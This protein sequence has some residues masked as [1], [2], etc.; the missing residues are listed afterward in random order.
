MK[1]LNLGCGAVFSKEKNW[2]NI[3]FYSSSQFVSSHNLLEGIP[4]PD[5]NFDVIYHS[6]VLE[7]FTKHEALIFLKECYR[8]L[9]PNGIIRI[10]VPDLECIIHEYLTNLNLLKENPNDEIISQ[11]YNWIMLEL[12]DQL[13]RN[14]NGG[15]MGKFLIKKDLK[16]LD[17]IIDRVGNEAVKY[18]EWKLL[19]GSEEIKSNKTNKRSL[20]TF[21]K[22]RKKKNTPSVHDEIGKFRLSGEVHQ[23][24]YDQFSLKHLIHEVGFNEITKNDAF[25]SQIPNWNS[26]NLD[27]IDG[28]IRK[29]DSLFMEAYKN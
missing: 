5:S 22:N 4:F 26:Y 7:H 6:H 8:V 25:S 3:D 14:Y 28:S 16:I 24:M 27:T 19:Q 23:W 1:L 21:L 13:T 15:E 29:P 17:Y 2:T 20:F 10:V 18:R 12:L 11:K 9:K